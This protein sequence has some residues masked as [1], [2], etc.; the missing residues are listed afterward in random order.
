MSAFL[1]VSDMEFAYGEVT[2]LR[3]L[4]LEVEE[5]TISCVMGRNG[6]GK[7]TFLRNVVGLEKSSA[8]NVLMDGTDITQMEAMN[9]LH[10]ELDMFRKVG[11]SFH[12]YRLRKTSRLD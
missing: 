7:T 5:G 1:K 6:V 2:V 10:E 12:F 11:K 8:G 4:D 9:G 3:G